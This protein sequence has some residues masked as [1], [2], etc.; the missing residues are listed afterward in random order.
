[1]Y[2]KVRQREAKDLFEVRDAAQNEAVLTFAGDRQAAAL[3]VG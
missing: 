3:N 1:M 2:L